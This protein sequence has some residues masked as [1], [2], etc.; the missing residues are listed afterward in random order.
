MKIL[1][2]QE[3]KELQNE[4]VN[5]WAFTLDVIDSVMAE[6]LGGDRI[7]DSATFEIAKTQHLLNLYMTA[8]KLK[9][10]KELYEHIK[11]ANI[12]DNGIDYDWL[13]QYLVESEQIIKGSLELWHK[14]YRHQYMRD[15]MYFALDI[16]ISNFL[17]KR[18]IPETDRRN[19]MGLS[20]ILNKLRAIK[21]AAAKNNNKERRE[22]TLAAMRNPDFFK[23]CQNRREK[24][25]RIVEESKKHLTASGRYASVSLKTADRYLKR[26]ENAT[27]Q[28]C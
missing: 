2:E 13:Q 21:S 4:P 27:K 22:D 26:I 5:N 20:A 11:C 10:N 3:A 23:N 12:R 9:N 28:T 15:R 6:N 7:W 16:E 19:L 1:T 18:Y 24:L 8:F 14:Q 17:V 25:L